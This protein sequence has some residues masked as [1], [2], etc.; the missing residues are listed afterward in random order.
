MSFCRG[1]VI[2]EEVLLIT[3]MPIT[4]GRD[5]PDSEEVRTK[6]TA[7]SSSNTTVATFRFTVLGFYLAAAGLIVESGPFPEK[8]LFLFL[9]Q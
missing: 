7:L 5:K 8:T 3:E 4:G 2:L 1:V 9:I 6:Y